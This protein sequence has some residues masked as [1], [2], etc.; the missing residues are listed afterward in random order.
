L[1]EVAG[2]NVLSFIYA[3]CCFV[4]GLTVANAMQT[5]AISYGV[6][7]TWAVDPYITGAALAL[8]ICYIVFGG[9]RRIVAVSDAI[10]PVKVAVFFGATLI[11]IS[12]H[13]GSLVAALEL[14]IKGAFK[15]EALMGGALG[16]TIMQSMTSGLNLSLTATESGLG[17]AAILFGYTGSNDAVRNGLMGMVSAFVSSLVCF[18]VALCIVMSGVWDSGLQSTA[19]TIASF[20]TV[21]GAWGGWIV[22][23]LSISFGI[24]VTVSYAY[25]TRAAWL[26]VTNG[27]F[28]LFFALAYCAAGFA[29]AIV[30]VHRMWTAVQIMNGVLLAIN[31]FGLL[32]LMPR[33]VRSYYGK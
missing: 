23:F 2:G 17:T 9:A 28:E 7:T 32:L 27:R 20:N 11:I 29:G 13:S 24:G 22:T 21:F 3:L 25:I 30:D 15:P 12:Y 4:F 16:I 19:L 5:H 31:L 8:F 33:L 1:K 26:A 6:H 10:V 14:M 18:I